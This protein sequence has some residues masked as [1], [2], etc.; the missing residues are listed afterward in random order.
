MNGHHHTG[1]SSIWSIWELSTEDIW[2]ESTGTCYSWEE[3]TTQDDVFILEIV[4]VSTDGKG[5]VE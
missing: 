2:N 3:E 1:G 5:K 4:H